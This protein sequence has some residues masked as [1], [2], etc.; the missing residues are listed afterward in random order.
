GVYGHKTYIFLIFMYHSFRHEHLKNMF[1]C[2]LSN[3]LHQWNMTIYTNILIT[4][5]VL[6]L[7]TCPF[8]ITPLISMH[9]LCTIFMN[10]AYTVFPLLLFS[11]DKILKLHPVY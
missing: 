2:P 10:T 8:N 9:I 5:K 3:W 7:E 1:G 11:H 6:N 4:R